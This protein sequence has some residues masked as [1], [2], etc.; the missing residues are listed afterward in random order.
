MVSGEEGLH[1]C[2]SFHRYLL[3]PRARPSALVVV[4]C[5]S[6]QRE[7]FA[8]PAAKFGFDD[9]VFYDEVAGHSGHYAVRVGRTDP[10]V[11]A[12]MV[13]VYPGIESARFAKLLTDL[14]I[15]RYTKYTNNLKLPRSQHQQV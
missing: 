5:R 7:G 9:K 11:D 14:N 2:R 4:I 1:R 6:W 10:N 12:S 15:N 13:T 3:L 8:L